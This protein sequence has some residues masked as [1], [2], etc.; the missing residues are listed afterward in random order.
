MTAQKVRWGVLAT[1]GIAAQFAAD[2]ALVEGAEPAAVGSRSR[3]SA[4]AFA[5]RFGFARAH[6]SY[7][8]LAAD[9][10]VD[11]V[12]VA[13]P[14]ALHFDAAM[15]CV[16]AGK[17][18]LVEKPVTLDLPQAARLVAAA[19]EREVFL[20]EAMWMRM[21]PAIRKIAELVDDG[22]IG[23]IS[24]VHADFGLHGPFP[25]EHRLR[26]PKLGGGALLDLG[27]YPINLV[28]LILGAPTDVRSWA[29]LTPEG[30]DENTGVLMGYQNGAI[31]A[32]TCSIN[33]ESRNAAS[34]TGTEGRIDL[35]P[36]F[37]VP[38]EFTLTR[39]GRA[40]ETFQ[41]PFP[42]RG[43]QFEAAE[44]QRCILAGEVESP[45]MPHATTLEVMNLLDTIRSEIGVAY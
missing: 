3:E 30:V 7:E 45:L 2:L 12:Y 32:L 15:A 26:D 23:W 43:Y 11:V 31:A 10:E 41:F 24:A 44:V 9:D 40:P 38:R 21:N 39:P 14:H 13:T 6:G 17:G 4:E 8:A 36:G 22:A 28:H 42:G 19:R 1:G 35:P 20:M 16:E 27:V 5:E 25:P 33:G 37:F 18:V 29:H 34:L